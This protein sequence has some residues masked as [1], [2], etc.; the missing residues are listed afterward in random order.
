MILIIGFG[1]RL[2]PIFTFW[3]I[4]LLKILHSFEFKQIIK[5]AF[6]RRI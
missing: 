4:E 1:V 6:R 3:E 5:N 2:Y